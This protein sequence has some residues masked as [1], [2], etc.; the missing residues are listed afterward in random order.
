MVGFARFV[1]IVGLVFA[2]VSAASLYFMVT[3]GE[4]LYS[5]SRLRSSP[6]LAE[7]AD[8]ALQAIA[9]MRENLLLEY[10]KVFAGM[11]AG[12]L[13]IIATLDLTPRARTIVVVAAAAC[14]V[15]LFLS[16]F[17]VRAAV[18]TIG[19]VLVVLWMGKGAETKAAA[20]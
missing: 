4:E 6:E 5:S 10:L 2:V 17:W 8:I 1:F 15:A 14:V 11:A 12:T 7:A 19:L 13:G 16:Q 3:H 20:R 9:N 18:F